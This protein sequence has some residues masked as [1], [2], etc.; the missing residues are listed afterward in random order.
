[1]LHRQNGRGHEHRDLFAIGSRLESRPNRDFSLAK[2]HVA[3]DQPV[4][5]HLLLHVLLHRLR[6]RQ[7]I[8]GVLVHETR[9]EFSLQVSVR[10]VSKP[11]AGAAL[12]V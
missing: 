6:R 4:H 1:M 5:G 12:G 9:L 11:S 3:T 7:L 2:T 10:G 8:R